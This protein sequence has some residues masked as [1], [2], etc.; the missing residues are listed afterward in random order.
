M[1]A[2]QQIWLHNSHRS[3][4]PVHEFR[5]ISASIERPESVFN[6]LH[7]Q[8]SEVILEFPWKKTPPVLLKAVDLGL[9]M[10]SDFKY[11]FCFVVEEIFELGN[12]TKSR[13][14]GVRDEAQAN[15][16]IIKRLTSDHRCS[17]WQRTLQYPTIRRLRISIRLSVMKTEYIVPNTIR[18]LDTLL[19]YAY[20]S[21]M[22]TAAK[23]Q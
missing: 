15:G 17:D 2:T 8:Q 18:K 14:L 13:C 4:Q 20:D 12:T 1:I 22:A 7:T 16:K 3:P 21:I 5:T 11:N 23:Q 9:E 10:S 19:T 6:I